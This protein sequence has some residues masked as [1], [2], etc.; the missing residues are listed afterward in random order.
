MKTAL[1]TGSF[2][3]IT[4][5]HFDLI[6]RTAALFERVEVVI[7]R[8]SEK[9][10]LFSE[11][12]RLAWLSAVCREAGENVRVAISEDTVAAYAKERGIS[13]IVKGVRSAADLAYEQ[14]MAALN[15][16]AG[17]CETLFLPTAPA[18]SFVSSSAVREFLRRGLDAR[19]LLPETIADDVIAAYAARE[20]G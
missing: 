20:N 9:K 8:N 4:R 16:M 11:A 14:D 19:S 15:R 10:P 5:G 1:I 17:G 18:L 2:D 3:P 12:E 13:L 7:F 6:A